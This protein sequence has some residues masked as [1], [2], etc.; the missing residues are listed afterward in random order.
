MV[1]G[2][3]TRETDMQREEILTSVWI[4]VRDNYF[5]LTALRA[6]TLFAF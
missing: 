4:Q 2:S 5:T 6:V 3:L 1:L